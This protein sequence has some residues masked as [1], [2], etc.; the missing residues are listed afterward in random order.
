IAIRDYGFPAS[1]TTALT[2]ALHDRVSAHLADKWSPHAGWCQQVLFFADLRSSTTT[3]KSS[4]VAGSDS[5]TL[6]S[7]EVDYKVDIKLKA[8]REDGQVKVEERKKTFD[9]EVRDLIENPGRKR[10][11]TMTTTTT[12]SAPVTEVKVV[13]KDKVVVEGEGAIEDE[14]R[15]DERDVKP[16]ID[17][18]DRDELEVGQGMKRRM[19]PTSTELKGRGN[20]GRR[21]KSK[22]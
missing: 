4:E 8:G 18:E 21:R 6:V 22:E 20:V 11:R 1:K 14:A 10:R 7:S 17:D 19:P 2:P 12:A 13:L 16:V 5:T 3:Q 9:E 15:P